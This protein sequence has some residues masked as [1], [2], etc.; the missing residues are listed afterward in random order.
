MVLM[1]DDYI[2]PTP[3]SPCDTQLCPNINI[4]PLS[5]GAASN[6]PTH[7]VLNLLAQSRILPLPENRVSP[8]CW[9]RNFVLPQP[10][11]SL[12]VMKIG[13]FVGS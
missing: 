10:I 6:G 11:K 5:M 7:F 13:A 4:E 1:H 3:N 8:I 12:E 9:S 2:Q